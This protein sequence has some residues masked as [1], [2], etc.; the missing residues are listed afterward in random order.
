MPV[1]TQVGISRR[2]AKDTRFSHSSPTWL[3]SDDDDNM[4]LP[5]VVE[6]GNA[7]RCF[8][9]SMRFV[10]TWNRMHQ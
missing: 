7:Q 1:K 6:T 3:T 10:S 2:A 9:Y 5:Q 4:Q 8:K